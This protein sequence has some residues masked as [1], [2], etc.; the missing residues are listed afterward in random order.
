MSSDGEQPGRSYR[1]REPFRVFDEAK[2]WQPHSPESLHMGNH[3]EELKRQGIEAM[4]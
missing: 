3:L 2:D 1:P 4:D